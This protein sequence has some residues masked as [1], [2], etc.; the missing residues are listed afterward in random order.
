MYHHH[1]MVWS[2]GGTMPYHSMVGTMVPGRLTPQ[3]C[4]FLEHGVLRACSYTSVKQ[5]GVVSRMLQSGESLWQ[6]RARAEKIGS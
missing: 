6:K 5:H 2:Y 4:T 3:A 1:G